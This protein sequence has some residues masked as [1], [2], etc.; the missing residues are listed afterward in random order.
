MHYFPTYQVLLFTFIIKI[1][2]K[3]LWANNKNKYKNLYLEETKGQ[4]TRPGIH[5]PWSRS[6]NLNQDPLAPNSTCFPIY[7]PS[8]ASSFQCT[9]H[10]L[11]PNA[12][13]LDIFST[14]SWLISLLGSKWRRVINSCVESIVFIPRVSARRCQ[15]NKILE[16]PRSQW[17]QIKINDSR[18]NGQIHVK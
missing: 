8:S 14:G 15:K 13:N 3:S 5:N 6:Q 11:Q 4:I 12:R 1:C 10:N 18:S 17:W 9:M 16:S 2:I 7:H